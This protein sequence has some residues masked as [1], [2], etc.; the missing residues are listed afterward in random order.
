[1][2]AWKWQEF[3][4]AGKFVSASSP[5]QQAGPAIA[6]CCPDPMPHHARLSASKPRIKKPTA[7]PTIHHKLLMMHHTSK[8]SQVNLSNLRLRGGHGF[9]AFNAT[10]L[11]SRIATIFFACARVSSR[12]LA[13]PP[14]WPIFARYFAHLLFSFRHCLPKWQAERLPYNS[15]TWTKYRKRVMMQ[16]EKKFVSARMPKPA[17]EARARKP[18]SAPPATAALG[19]PYPAKGLCRLR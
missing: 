4:R 8:R 15:I 13:S 2:R 10:R 9:P 12:R 17:G 3:V 11:A 1:M 18:A 19:T 6:G 14:R 16:Q 7:A 5:N